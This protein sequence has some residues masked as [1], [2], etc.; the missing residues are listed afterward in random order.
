MAKKIQSNVCSM[1][2]LIPFGSA[3]SANSIYGRHTPK[4]QAHLHI[5]ST[6]RAVEHGAVWLESLL[7][8]A[9]L[10]PHE[11]ASGTQPPCI[12]ERGGMTD[13]PGVS[14]HGMNGRSRR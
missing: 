9:P 8:L 11:A 3:V 14:P 5:R 2:M 13:R 1:S 10:S 7:N 6:V 12:A 4:L